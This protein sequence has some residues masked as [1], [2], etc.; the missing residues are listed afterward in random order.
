MV[1]GSQRAAVAQVCA[2]SNSYLAAVCTSGPAS[3]WNFD[4]ADGSTV[5]VDSVGTSPAT[6]R[7]ASGVRA[8]AAGPVFGGVATRG[9]W[10]DGTCGAGLTLGS[11]SRFAAGPATWEF[12]FRP[13]IPASLRTSFSA[14]SYPLLSLGHLSAWVNNPNAESG[15]ADFDVFATATQRNSV[16][17]GRGEL[18]LGP[19]SHLVV[20]FDGLSVPFLSA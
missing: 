7:T 10:I 19:W 9:A 6:S 20:M 3:L 2:G 1:A 11:P 15:D 13:V 14:D 12:W 17:S 5:F 18:P 4:D 16:S 8:G